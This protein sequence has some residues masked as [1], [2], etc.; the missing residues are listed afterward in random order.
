MASPV[1]LEDVSVITPA[2]FGLGLAVCNTAA[3]TAAKTATLANYVLT[4]GAPVSV[5]FTYANTASNAT[6]NLNGTGAKPI[7]YKGSAIGNDII[8]A[9][10]TAT[11]IY[12]G[13]NYKITNI[14]TLAG[15][16]SGTVKSVAASDGLITDQTGNNPIQNTGTV[17][18]NLKSTT[19]HANSVG[20]PEDTNQIYPVQ[21]DKDGVPC[22]AVPW[23]DEGVK[24]TES[25]TDASYEL[26][27]AKT[28]G[29]AEKTEGVSK[30]AKATMNPSTGAFTV[31][32]EISGTGFTGDGVK[33]SF[34][35]QVADLSDEKVPSE[36]LVKNSLDE[37]VAGPSSTVVDGA[38]VVFDNTTGKLVKTSGKYFESGDTLSNDATKIPNSKGIIEDAAT[39]CVLT[40]GTYGPDTQRQNIT[41][42][43]TVLGAVKQLEYREETNKTNISSLTSRMSDCESDIDTQTARIDNIVAL[44]SGSTQGDAELMD[45]RVKADG[46]TA[47]SAG[48]AVREQIESVS[49][50]VDVVANATN[51]VDKTYD[52]RID[53]IVNTNA[54]I[55][56]K[57]IRATG[58]KSTWRYWDG[59]TYTLPEDA[60]TIY[61]NIRN[62]IPNGGTNPNYLIVWVF[63]DN[64]GQ[65]IST[66]NQTVLVA[67]VT[68]PSGAKTVMPKY[69]VNGNS[70]VNTEVI[71]DVTATYNR[72]IVVNLNDDVHIGDYTTSEISEIVSE[73]KPVS[74]SIV[75]SKNLFKANWYQATIN[76]SGVYGRSTGIHNAATAELIPV[77][78]S[79]MYTLSWKWNSNVQRLYL[80]EYAA[81]K[82]FIQDSTIDEWTKRTNAVKFTTTATTKF[83]RFKTYAQ[84]NTEYEEVVLENTQLECGGA[85]STYMSTSDI[86]NAVNIDKIADHRLIIPN[87]YHANGYL[88]GKVDAIRTLMTNAAGNYDAFF[89]ISDIHW[90]INQQ[91]S[92]ALIK[93]LKDKL[94]I[95]RLF[96]GGDNYDK[97]SQY[98]ITDFFK[99]LDLGF[100]ENNHY[101]VT[102]N[103]EYKGTYMTDPIVWLYLNSN[104]TDIVIGDA[105][106]SYYYVDNKPQKIRYIILNVYA[107]SANGE[108]AS[109]YF[110]EAQQNWFRDVALNLENGW[111]AIVF[112]HVIKEIANTTN[113]LY[114]V[115]GVTEEIYSICDNYS[116]NGEI[117]AIFAGHTHRDRITHTT[118]GIPVIITACDKNGLWYDGQGNPDIYETRASG[119]IAEQAFDVVIVDKRNRLISAVRIGSKAF[120]GIDS[121]LGTQVEMRQVNFKTI[122]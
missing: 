66:Y 83:I 38:V 97:W 57:Y 117:I 102:G 81:D 27:F 51:G 47:S 65:E 77:E 32:G 105:G 3:D 72:N 88:E 6:L 85:Q 92:P 9:G 43:T 78:S 91:H 13:T 26:L 110:E 35:S 36:K 44:P 80:Y 33:T 113:V 15:P 74:N 107:N 5:T 71:Y 76:D 95:P 60:V 109:V 11:F 79:T 119:T 114:N 17:K 21:L 103:H 41:K 22:V 67:T 50:D 19:K 31:N 34:A 45:I 14:D 53:D 20:N 122:E 30:S 96:N 48:D 82:S 8:V 61:S 62:V 115:Q 68:I 69:G 63:K 120:N 118:G 52:K 104:K 12:D 87:Y 112:T 18:L 116:G 73:V 64:N 108:D 59:E 2:K 1:Q 28:A 29:T 7:F 99:M 54:F 55:D 56:S 58:V 16:G 39:K 101:N 121:N 98:Y 94:N 86:S 89:F 37:K 4:E 40:T 90:E 24:Q 106:R 25:S 75:D 111:K 23:T 49:N 46:T 100:G 70:A 42:N 93:Y 84:D 10:D